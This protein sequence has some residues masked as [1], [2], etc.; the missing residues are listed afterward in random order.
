M[1]ISTVST[2]LIVKGLTE[3]SSLS[4][5]VLPALKW[6]CQSKTLAQLNAYVH[7]LLPAY[8]WFQNKFVAKFNADSLFSIFCHE[9]IWHTWKIFLNEDICTAEQHSDDV[10]TS[11]CQFE[12]KFPNEFQ[13]FLNIHHTI[14]QIECYILNTIKLRANQ[15]HSNM[16]FTSNDLLKDC[17]I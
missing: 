8:Q 4:A 11:R 6:Q 14:A 12:R 3:C 17:N 9:K 2:F 7:K 13:Y 16:L 15:W 1:C 10:K 5:D